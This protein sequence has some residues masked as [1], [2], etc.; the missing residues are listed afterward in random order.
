[1]QT[2]LLN[3]RLFLRTASTAGGLL[4]AATL[5]AVAGDVAPDVK[6]VPPPKGT[7][8]LALMQ[9]LPA[10]NDQDRNAAIAE[11]F[12][13]QAQQQGADL[14]IMPEMW[15]IGY[16]GPADMN[17]ATL[18]A[19]A[20]Q[21]VDAAGPWV[22]RFRRLARDLGMGIAAT[23]LECKNGK[24]RNSVSLFDRRGKLLFTY[25]KVHTC[26]F[27]FE[28]ALEP[29]AGWPVAPLDTGRD[30]VQ[31]GAMI[32]FDREFPESARS[33]MVNGAE[34]VIT[35]NACPL[36]PLR[37]AQFQIRGFENAMTMAMTNYPAPF[38]NGQSIVFAADGRLVKQC[39]ESEQLAVV[40]VD[41]MDLRETRSR[42]IWGN[43]W[44]RPSRYGD[45]A[46]P[47]DLPVFRRTNQHDIPVE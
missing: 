42:T 33:L 31:V 45:L 11:S 34:I 25:S 39:D 8:R 41:L 22:E 40:D 4:A 14:L 9:A 28:A 32:C 7:I 21:A 2:D 26:A 3:R 19:W 10:A 29:G 30:I 43:A 27:A 24:L 23:Y 35:P 36:D 37:L 15:N 46:K 47:A 1:M 44:R 17:E 18:D 38:H 20:A 6:S 16:R 13:R 12:C 5:P